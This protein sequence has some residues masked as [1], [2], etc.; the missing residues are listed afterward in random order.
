MQDAE[1]RKEPTTS[2]RPLGR[3]VRP[4]CVTSAACSE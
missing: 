2:L 4:G 3:V 1:Y